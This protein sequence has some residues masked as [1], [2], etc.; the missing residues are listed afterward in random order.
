MSRGNRDPG[1]VLV[2][3]I[4]Q[5]ILGLQSLQ[6]RR[7]PWLNVHVK[8]GG[9]IIEENGHTGLGNAHSHSSSCQRLQ[10]SL[11]IVRKQMG[12]WCLTDPVFARALLSSSSSSNST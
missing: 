5:R 7:V 9:L 1:V 2:V 10:V 11:S 3:A 4:H 6:N 12:I 8:T